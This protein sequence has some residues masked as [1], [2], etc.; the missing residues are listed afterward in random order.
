MKEL[1]IENGLCAEDADL[2]DDQVTEMIFK[3]GLSTADEVSDISGRGVGMD[4]ARAFLHEIDGQMCIEW[5]S[6]E[7][8]EK[9]FRAFQ[10]AINIRYHP[11]SQ[12]A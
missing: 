2:D 7:K 1:A 12:A 3:S 5:R 11:N 10:F 4:A 6:P 9:C 8:S